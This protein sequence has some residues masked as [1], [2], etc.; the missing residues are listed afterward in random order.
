MYEVGQIIFLVAKKAQSILAAQVCEQNVKK[1]L[2]G[3]ETT[4]RV[5]I[6]GDFDDPAD[7]KLYDLDRIDADIYGSPEEAAESLYK[8]AQLAIDGLVSGAI[9]DAAKCFDYQPLPSK[10]PVRSKAKKAS[11]SR[12]SKT[13]EK[14]SAPAPDTK[15]PED[16]STYITMPDGTQARLKTP[17]D[18]IASGE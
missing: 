14:T 7:I 8:T 9:E 1:T 4:F 12:R 11:T 5:R 18:N 17:I 10:K 15:P 13:V 6:G 3:E 16:M 2:V